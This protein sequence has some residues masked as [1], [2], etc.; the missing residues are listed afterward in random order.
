MAGQRLVTEL[1][2]VNRAAELT[3]RILAVVGEPDSSDIHA[4]ADLLASQ[5]ADATK[6]VV[7]GAGHNVNLER[8]EE[9]RQLL[10]EFLAGQ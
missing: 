4:V 7:P 9:F 8:P 6:V 2:G 3:A 1:D 5:A 10:T